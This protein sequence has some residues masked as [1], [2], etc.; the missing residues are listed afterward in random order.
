MKY[1]FILTFLL[2]GQSFAADNYRTAIIKE[3]KQAFKVCFELSTDEA[4]EGCL[5]GII[6]PLK[7]RFVH[8][9]NGLSIGVQKAFTPTMDNLDLN[10]RKH[11]W[12]KAQEIIDSA[13]LILRYL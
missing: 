3:H 4:K 8:K 9:K 5:N 11:E 1:I 12:S 2:V 10:I 7:E 6:N 13:V